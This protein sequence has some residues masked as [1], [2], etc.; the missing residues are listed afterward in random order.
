MG[1][2]N[3][4]ENRIF[5]FIIFFLALFLVVSLARSILTIRQKENIVLD[6]EDKLKGLQSQNTQFHQKIEN[7]QSP[8]YI[9]KQAR[10]KLNLGREGDYAVILPPLT[11]MPTATPAPLLENWEKWREL[12]VY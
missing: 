8:L 9:E 4:L 7:L 12:F 10:E 11:P 2:S 1:M 3:L 6:E 5:R